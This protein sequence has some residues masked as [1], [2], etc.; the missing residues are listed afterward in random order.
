MQG[1]KTEQGENNILRL[2][3]SEQVLERLREMI[4][5]G[6]LSPGDHMPSERALMERFGVGRP[7]VRE[8]LQALHTQG[9]ITISHG[10][11]SRVNE[12]SAE[13]VLVQSDNVARLLLEAAPANLEHLK[14][15]RKMFELGVVRAVANMATQRDVENLR[16][17]HTAQ[18]RHFS[19]HTAI[20]LFIEADMDFHKGIADILGNPVI[21]AA[22]NAMLRW[23][24]EYHISLLHWSDKE[25]VTLAE[26]K[27]IIDRIES[28]DADGAAEAMQKHLDRSQDLY[29]SRSA[30][31]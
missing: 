22:S 6:E 30:S 29:S 19:D 26:H 12:L 1:G 25:D 15:A 21:S 16:A 24:C 8:A 5:S 14:E 9:L 7:A 13:T 17:L 20:R 10:E 27:Q 4:A 11:R 31:E 18:V 3:L 2:K 28:N 23:L